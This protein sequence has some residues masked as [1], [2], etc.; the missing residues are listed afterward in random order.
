MTLVKTI[1]IYVVWR[2]IEKVDFQEDWLGTEN[3][4]IAE[5]KY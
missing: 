2:P 4:E 3:E 5:N 1:F